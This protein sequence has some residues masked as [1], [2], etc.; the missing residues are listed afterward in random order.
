[1][2]PKN[3]MFAVSYAPQNKPWFAVSSYEPKTN[4]GLLCPMSPKQSQVCF[5]LL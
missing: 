1:M 5:D 4:P 3:P 2:C